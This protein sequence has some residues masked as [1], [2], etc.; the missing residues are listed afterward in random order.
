MVPATRSARAID[1]GEDGDGDGLG[2][3]TEK[4]KEEKDQVWLGHLIS[5]LFCVNSSGIM[6]SDISSNT[7][8]A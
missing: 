3:R 8:C 6:L 4:K 2:G 7:S 5:Y 1:G